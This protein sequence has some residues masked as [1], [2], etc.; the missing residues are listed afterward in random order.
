MAYFSKKLSPVECN[1][2]IHDKELLAIVRCLN[3]WRAELIGLKKPFLILT[4]HK[5]LKYFMTSRKL[6]ER[7][8]RWSQTLSQFN[9]HLKFRAGRQGDRPDSLSRRAQDLPSTPEDPRLKGREFQLIQDKMILPKDGYN[10]SSLSPVLSGRMPRGTQ[11]FEDEEMQQ[12][13]DRGIKE[14]FHSQELLYKS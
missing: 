7:H 6:T 4:D 3:E 12:L 11:V 1:Y 5:N 8:V 2:N 13:W 10:V 9:F 14:D